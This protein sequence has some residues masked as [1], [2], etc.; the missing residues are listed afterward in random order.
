MKLKDDILLENAYNK[1]ITFSEKT[2][3]D[4]LGDYKLSHPTPMPLDWKSIFHNKDL[5]LIKLPN[6]VPMRNKHNGKW[7]IRVKCNGKKGFYCFETQL[8]EY[9]SNDFHPH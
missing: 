1:V 7:Y 6:E 9:D 3:E 8:F 2:A 4:E 5:N